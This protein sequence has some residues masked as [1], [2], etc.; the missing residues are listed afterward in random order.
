MGSTTN[1]VAY[2][3]NENMLAEKYAK[4]SFYHET[5]PILHG[6]SLK[7][8]LR[9]AQMSSS[10]KIENVLDV[11]CG[12]GYM[13]R[14]LVNEGVIKSAIGI[15]I[16][17]EMIELAKSAI[18][19]DEKKHFEYYST[20][21]EDFVG[22]SN[23]INKFPLIISTFMLCHMESVNELHEV[24]SHIYRLCSGSFVGLL[25]NP[26]LNPEDAVKLRKYNIKHDI[27]SEI[28]DGEKVAIT[29]DVDTDNQFTLIDFWYSP[30][31]YENLFRKAGFSTFQW[32]PLEIDPDITEE[33][34]AFFADVSY[35]HIGFMAHV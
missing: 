26:F 3:Y 13:T 5:R 23:S 15:D 12:D 27:S 14:M 24:L 35:F 31:T 21:V 30:A 28:T 10:E 9:R 16:S 1:S 20:K 19:Q 8:L 33:K 18:Q 6:F 29:F 32:V 4:C 34:K 25:P 2:Q 17:K 11:G 7:M 22:T